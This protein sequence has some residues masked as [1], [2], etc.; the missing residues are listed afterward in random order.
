M[1]AL[2]TSLNEAMKRDAAQ[3]AFEVGQRAW[4]RVSLELERFREHLRKVLGL[5]PSW[6][7]QA[8][9]AELYLACAAVA[10]DAEARAV[11]EREFRSHAESFMHQLAPELPLIAASLDLS[12]R[13][14]EGI[15]RYAGRGP[16]F[17]WLSACAARA[18]RAAQ[19]VRE[20]DGHSSRSR[21]VS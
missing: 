15:A 4:P 19:A 1:L 14:Y 20:Y 3:A 7:W 8:H 16:L 17:P 12:T 6:N 21:G 13:H 9:A 2:A 18:A 10:G 5:T 11:L